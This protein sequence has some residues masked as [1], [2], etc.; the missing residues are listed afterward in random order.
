MKY[1]LYDPYVKSIWNALNEI[2]IKA[3]KIKVAYVRHSSN[4]PAYLVLQD[5]LYDGYV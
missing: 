3:I 2:V 4:D 5:E 1:L